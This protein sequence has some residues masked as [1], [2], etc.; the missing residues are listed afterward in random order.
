MAMNLLPN[1][2]LKETFSSLVNSK[3]DKERAQKI[4]DICNR[5]GIT[6]EQLMSAYNKSR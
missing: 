3:N 2:N 4:A 1:Q 6:K 5:N